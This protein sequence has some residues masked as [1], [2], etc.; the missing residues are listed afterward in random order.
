LGGGF[1]FFN[2]AFLI[3][4]LSF[5]YCV[6]LDIRGLLIDCLFCLSFGGLIWLRDLYSVSTAFDIGCTMSSSADLEVGSREKSFDLNKADVDADLQK[7]DHVPQYR[8]DAFGDEE[9][10]EVK[11]KVLKWWYV[12]LASVFDT[13]VANF[14]FLGNADCV[15]DD[16]LC[17]KLKKKSNIHQLWSPKPSPWVFYHCQPQSQVLDLCR[18]L[19]LISYRQQ[20]SR[21]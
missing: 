19:V 11:Y 21:S 20:I 7:P 15:C 9:N 16:I 5:S 4:I 6:F 17:F 10:A 14:D 1:L 3:L 18:M 8:Q 13:P 2:C 12:C